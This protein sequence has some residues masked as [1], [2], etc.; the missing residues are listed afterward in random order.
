MSA[1]IEGA[2]HEQ[3]R[4]ALDAF[5]AARKGLREARGTVAVEAALR[6][7]AVADRRVRA[8]IPRNSSRRCVD[9]GT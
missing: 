9:L 8:T 4:R 1:S 6:E 2:V 7:L 5:R 3:H